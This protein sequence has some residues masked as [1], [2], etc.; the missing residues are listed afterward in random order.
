VL[1]VWLAAT[2]LQPFLYHY[3]LS[4]CICNTK[5]DDGNGIE[6]CMLLQTLAAVNMHKAADAHSTS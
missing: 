4:A 1:A 6:P 3:Y 2:V 5:Q